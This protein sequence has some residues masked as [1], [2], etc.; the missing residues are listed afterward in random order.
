V[1]LLRRVSGLMAAP[2]K[3]VEMAH[4]ALEFVPAGAG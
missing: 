2:R 1:A 4:L 3:P